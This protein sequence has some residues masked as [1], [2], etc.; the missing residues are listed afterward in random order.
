LE[1]ACIISGRKE[2]EEVGPYENLNVWA[3]A[4]NHKR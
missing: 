2:V 3:R 1:K 4:L